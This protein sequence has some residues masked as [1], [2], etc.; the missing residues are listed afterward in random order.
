MSAST[1]ARKT[2]RSDQPWRRTTFFHHPDRLLK[3]GSRCSAEWCAN[4]I[5]WVVFELEQGPQ[6]MLRSNLASQWGENRVDAS[7]RRRQL[8]AAP[9]HCTFALPADLEHLRKKSTSSAR[10][11]LWASRDLS[12]A[13]RCAYC[14]LGYRWATQRK[15]Y[16]R[17]G[18]FEWIHF[19]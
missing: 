10:P 6:E 15:P 17:C 8:R 2:Y 14:A 19:A 13:H 4:V 16:V 1:A 12:N 5:S 9:H 11:S 3:S 18:M 7:R